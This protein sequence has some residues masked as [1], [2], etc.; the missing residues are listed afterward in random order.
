MDQVAFINDVRTYHA[1]L[2]QIELIGEAVKFIPS[3]IRASHPSIAWQSIIATRNILTHVYFGVDDD[4]IWGII[5]SE[6]E[7]LL[8]ILEEIRQQHP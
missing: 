5:D 2:R 4:I 8:V 7:P 6:I 3:D 1:T